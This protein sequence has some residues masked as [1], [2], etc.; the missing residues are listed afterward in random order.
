MPTTIEGWSLAV[1]FLLGSAATLILARLADRLRLIDRPGGRKDH[2]R[3]VPLVGGLAIFMALLATSW[4]A[5]V[6]VA[7]AYFLFALSLVIAVGLWDDVADIAPRVKFAIQIL[8][9]FVMIFGAGVELVS[10]G[11][12][13]GWRPIGLWIFAIPLTVFAVV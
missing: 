3:P 5:G 12:L 9:S 10:V 8:A 13:V 7:S 11:D 2:A 1:A 6:G 4:M